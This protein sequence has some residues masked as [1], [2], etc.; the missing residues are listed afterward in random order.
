M[1]EK[2]DNYSGVG[3][4]TNKKNESQI[5]RNDSPTTVG[6]AGQL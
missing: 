4:Q 5:K 3:K 1:M 6:D 2:Q